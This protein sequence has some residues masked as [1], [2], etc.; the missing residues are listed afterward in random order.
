MAAPNPWTTSEDSQLRQLHAADTPIRTI[1]THLGRS[2]SAV[3]RRLR[4]LGLGATTRIHTA[5]AISM[6]D[7]LATALGVPDAG[8]QP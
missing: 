7:R 4:H 2:R 1:A 3:D 5:A 8:P 6:L